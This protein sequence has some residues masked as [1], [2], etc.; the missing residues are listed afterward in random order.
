[1]EVLVGVVPGTMNAWAGAMD[2]KASA[3]EA[4]ATP[5]DDRLTES[6]LPIGTSLNSLI[7][8]KRHILLST[9]PQHIPDL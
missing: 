2:P 6:R 7:C 8:N 1:M 9:L 4:V 5:K 3:T